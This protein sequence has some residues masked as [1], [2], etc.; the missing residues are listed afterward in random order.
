MPRVATRKK[1]NQKL[2][3]LL[4]KPIAIELAQPLQAASK[5]L[6]FINKVDTN[7]YELK[8]ALMASVRFHENRISE[9]HS[10]IT[11]LGLE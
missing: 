9:L 1:V 5:T 6:D 7:S 11:K 3:E 10:T 2:S 8:N 4:T